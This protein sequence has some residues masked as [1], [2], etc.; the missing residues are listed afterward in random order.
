MRAALVLRTVG[1]VSGDDRRAQGSFRPI[2]GRLD[3][4]IIEEPQE[5]TSVL[6]GT[7]AIQQP[8][9]VFIAK[10]TIPK[11]MRQSALQLSFPLLKL[12]QWERVALRLPTRGLLQYR[13]TRRS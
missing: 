3:P 7:A 13:F 5:I 8:L 2:I 10:D 9:I 11:V 12:R 1:D 4:G 6:L